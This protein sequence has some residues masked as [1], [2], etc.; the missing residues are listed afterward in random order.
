MHGVL[1]VCTGNICRSPMAEYLLKHRLGDN[2]DWEVGSAG[3]IAGAGMAASESAVEAMQEI[4]IDLR[5]HRSTPL[6]Q[7]LVDA[8]DLV[9]VMTASHRD[10]MSALFPEDRDKV[11][12]LKSFAQGR[13]SGDV[14]DP[15]GLTLTAY[16]EVR[17]QIEQALPGLMAFM[18]NITERREQA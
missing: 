4:G 12:L 1:F 15:I 14:A 3:V 13:N 9:V 5:S 7:E 16:R 18:K 2:T 6:V 10:Q 8:A 11:Y 17:E